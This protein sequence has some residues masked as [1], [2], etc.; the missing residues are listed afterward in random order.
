LWL[1]Q[2]GFVKS[3]ALSCQNARWFA[4][5]ELSS[6]LRIVFGDDKRIFMTK[7]GRHW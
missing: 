2:V 4:V 6:L 5:I 1:Q 3:R 7:G